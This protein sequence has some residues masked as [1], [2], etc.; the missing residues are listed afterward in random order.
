MFYYL[1]DKLREEWPNEF[2]TD[3]FNTYVMTQDKIDSLFRGIYHKPEDGD[4]ELFSQMQ[5]ITFY[6]K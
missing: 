1:S 2:R 3:F 6:T 5:F 4:E